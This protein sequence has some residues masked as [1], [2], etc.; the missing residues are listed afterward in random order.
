MKRQRTLTG[1]IPRNEPAALVPLLPIE[2]LLMIMNIYPVM[3]RLINSFFAKKF[4]TNLIEAV[5]QITFTLSRLP[6]DVD[7]CLVGCILPQ[8][9]KL[10]SHYYPKYSD[11]KR[12][13]D[14]KYPNA[15]T[16]RISPIA[17]DLNYNDNDFGIC[18]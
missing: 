18:H 14:K 10:V 5:G 17:Y 13:F 15:R 8:H 9:I 12:L 6:M 11:K 16:F 1:K 2:L 3:A 4:E 7:G